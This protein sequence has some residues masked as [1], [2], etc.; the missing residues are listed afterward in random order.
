MT[1]QST[2]LRHALTRPVRLV[3]LG[4]VLSSVGSGM[5]LSLLVVYLSQVRGIAT[6]I[7]GLVLSWMALVGLAM[8][9]IGGT[10][11]DRF[12]PRRVLVVALIVEAVGVAMYALVRDAPAAFGVATITALGG[13]LIWP[14]Q[15]TL[16]AQLSGEES[17]QRVFGVQFMLLNLG[18]GIG[19]LIAASLVDVTR[20]QT[21]VTLYVVDAAS[22]LIYIV[23]LAFVRG[24]GPVVALQSDPEE[25]A[26]GYREVLGD[27]RLRRLVLGCFVLVTFGYGSMDGGLPLYITTVTG[28]PVS[29]IGIVFAVNTFVIV[30]FQWLSLRFA[31]GRSRVGL[32]AT[33]GVMWAVSWLVMGGSALASGGVALAALCVGMLVF[34]LAETLWAPVQPALLNAL[35]PDHLRGRYNATSSW[36]WNVGGAIGPALAGLLIGASLGGL[37]IGIVAAGALIGSLAVLT[38]RPLLTAAEDGRGLAALRPEDGGDLLEA[39]MGGSTA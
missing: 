3:L 18:L 7:A 20:P 14:A 12:G 32:L 38:V 33:V 4:I 1:E 6:A 26:D 25:A 19:G 31:E 15:G 24:G 17:R 9:P 2:P 16:M 5:T 10:F 22:Y 39:D 30:A 35:A 21:F 36:A 23:L 27:R 34:A 13:A 28:L 11:I 8:A 37:W 29:R